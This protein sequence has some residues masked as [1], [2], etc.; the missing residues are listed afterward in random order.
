[1]GKNEILAQIKESL[2]DILDKEDFD[3][4]MGTTPA[5]VEGW[6]SL[7]HFQLVME[8]QEVYNIK[9]GAVA[10]QSWTKVGD[11]VETVLKS[12]NN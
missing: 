8:L 7:A 5:D 10:I 1:M 12:I 3:L 9:I 6:D 4:T 11:I 2:I